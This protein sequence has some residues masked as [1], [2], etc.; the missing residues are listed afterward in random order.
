MGDAVG[1]HGYQGTRVAD[2]VRRAGVSRKTFYELFASKDECFVATY[3]HWIERLLRTTVAAYE[4]QSAWVDGLRA[5]L[6]AL[7]SELARRPA[8]ARL[9]FVDALAAGEAIGSTRDAAM[10]RLATLFNAPGVPHPPLSGVL[11]AGRVGELN[12]VVRHEVA[13]GRA[14]QLPKLVPE[15]MYMMVLPFLGVDAAQRELSRNRA[16]P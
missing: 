2:V 16:T 11:S 6:T 13:A 1:D 14:E 8:V 4:S 15:L 12:E 10:E 7:L 5:A 9:C 3:T